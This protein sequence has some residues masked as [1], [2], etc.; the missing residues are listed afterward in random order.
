MIMAK[1]TP[2]ARTPRASS[3]TTSQSATLAQLQA[4]IAELQRQAEEIRRNE[5][6]EVVAR[7]KEAIAHYGLTAADLGLAAG[8]GKRSRKGAAASNGAIKYRDGA[9][10]WTGR[11]RRPQ[12]FIEALAAG[13]SEQDLLA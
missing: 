6:S 13:K 10:S 8:G 2:S 4:Q 1:R 5:I 12:W 9:N 11:G 3:N 7:I